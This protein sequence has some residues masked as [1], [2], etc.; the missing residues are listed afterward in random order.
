MKNN[1]GFV[2]I[3]III[4]L[5]AVFVIGGVVY[6]AGTKNNSVSQN[7]SENIVGDDKDA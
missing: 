1:K 5:I 7:I 4:A 6:Y 2:G 3:G